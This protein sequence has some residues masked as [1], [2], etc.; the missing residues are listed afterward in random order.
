MF[1]V[2]AWN[3]GGS[4]YG[5][6]VR[7]QDRRFFQRNWRT[8]TVALPDGHGVMTANLTD[9]FWTTCPEIRSAAVGR[10]A[11]SWPHGRPPRFTLVPTGRAAFR[12][13]R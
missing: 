6:R 10:L 4:G 9:T 11:P 1:T 12:L 7:R 3:N 5:L 8:V 13:R 2:T